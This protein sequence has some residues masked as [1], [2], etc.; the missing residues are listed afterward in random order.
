MK[1]KYKYSKIPSNLT[2]KI[3]KGYKEK[4]EFYFIEENVKKIVLMCKKNSIIYV[5]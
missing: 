1:Y 2:S 5:I 3:F 4:G